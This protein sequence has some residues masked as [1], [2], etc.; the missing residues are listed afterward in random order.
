MHW[1]IHF[2]S[3]MFI[4]LLME[5]FWIVLIIKNSSLLILLHYYLII[6]IQSKY[7][8]EFYPSAH[9]AVVSTLVS[10]R[11]CQ[12]CPYFVSIPTRHS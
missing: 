11:P 6:N 5:L 7:E 4:L 8:N 10:I 3:P 12:T 1:N 9:G 2:L